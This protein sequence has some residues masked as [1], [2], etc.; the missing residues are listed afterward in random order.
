MAGGAGNNW[1]IGYGLPGSEGPRRTLTAVRREVE[2][3]DSLDSI[4]VA[5][6]LAGGT[7]SGLGSRVTEELRDHF[8]RTSI[9]SVAV[10]PFHVGEVIPQFYNASLSLSHLLEAS[11]CVIMIENQI[12]DR[13]CR[14][15][16]KIKQPSY[17][18]LNRVIASHV[19]APA[20]PST[21]AGGSRHALSDTI[22]HVSGHPSFKFVAAQVVPT[23]PPQSLDFNSDSWSGLLNRTFQTNL[24]STL[25]L[26]IDWRIAVDSGS[27]HNVAVAS[28]LT[29]HGSDAL[30]HVDALHREIS[31]FQ[32]RALYAPWNP[33]PFM[34]C[35]RAGS[36]QGHQRAVTLLSNSMAAVRPAELLSTR[37]SEQFRS[38][39]FVHT[40][41]SNG[42]IEE[43]DLN[44]A[45]QRL[46][47]ACNDYA[48]L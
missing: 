26:G 22:R 9:V 47:Q 3:S 34:T 4:L 13:T 33:V 25:D 17:V 42:V 39:A 21:T 19:A 45:F 8:P 2:R 1:T 29:M 24:C 27:P 6:S 48:E 18:D 40:F 10:S 11:D 30:G 12:V 15:L 7:G 46:Q 28:I 35:T 31:R 20:L 44:L 32:N 43:D 16:L 14:E 23:I 5:S 41:L 38:R 36:F 37:G